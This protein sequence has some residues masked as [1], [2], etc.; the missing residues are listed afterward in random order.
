MNLLGKIIT[1]LIMLLSICFLMIAVMVNASHQNWKQM[2]LNNKDQ[3]DRVN[4]ENRQIR[5]Q[6]EQ[7]NEA[8]KTEKVARM[9][10]IQQLESQL[11]LA[12]QN[13]QQSE[14]QLSAA[15]IARQEGLARAE[16]AEA[17][18]K[19]QDAQIQN[20][21]DTMKTLVEDIATQRE[22]VVSMTNQIYELE[23]ERQ[24]LKSLQTDIAEENA[25]LTK[26][27]KK[28]GLTSDDLTRHIEPML[29]GYVVGVAE[30]TIAVNL[31]TDDGLHSGHSIDLHRDGRYVGSA[32]VTVAE[33]NRSAAR[34]DPEL[35]KIAIEKGDRVTTNWVRSQ[36]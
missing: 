12:L 7:K 27:M 8:I 22:K 30:N 9:L 2:A 4:Q 3:V 16:E 32:V 31:G 19:E 13:Y 34:I 21:R 24:N 18:L 14:Q 29:D 6:I 35:T 10:R 5:E 28:H 20:L 1:L 15:E 11:Q 25:K 17:R 33:P 36:K 26:V 23:G